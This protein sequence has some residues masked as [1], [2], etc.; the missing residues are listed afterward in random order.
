MAYLQEQ[1]LPNLL[2][3]RVNPAK[4]VELKRQVDHKLS[5]AEIAEYTSINRTIDKSPHDDI[6]YG[7][8]LRQPTDLI[9]ITDQCKVSEF[10]SSLAS[11][12]A[13]HVHELH[14]ESG[15]KIARNSTNYELATS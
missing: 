1:S 7:L 15:D 2:R 10:A 3:Y 14:K 12:V 9:H 8:G 6:A 13:S 11:S 5:S 4:H